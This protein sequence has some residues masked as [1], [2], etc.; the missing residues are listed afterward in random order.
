V[1]PLNPYLVLMGVVRA[2]VAT[3]AKSTATLEDIISK[4]AMASL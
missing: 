1:S 4:S 2:D 3:A